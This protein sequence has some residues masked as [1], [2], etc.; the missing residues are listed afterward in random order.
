MLLGTAKAR[1]ERKRRHHQ[2]V[3][4][5]VFSACHSVLDKAGSV[6]VEDLRHSIRG[7][8]RGRNTNR[9]LSGWV[10]GLIQ[11]GVEA[12][13]RR[14]GTS[15]DEINAAY[16]SQ[17]LPCCRAF[18]RRSGDARHCPRG[19]GMFEADY[20]AANNTLQRKSD[21][22]IGRYLPYR[23][24]RQVLEE[25]SRTP[26]P[27]TLLDQRSMRGAELMPETAQA[28]LQLLQVGQRRFRRQRRKNY[29][30]AYFR[31]RKMKQV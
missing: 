29:R 30:T 1:V 26:E 8:D 22:A 23:K 20:V 21:T 19:R 6:V 9:R 13:S 25:R 27:A 5:L 11:E 15:V 24:V 14:R 7:Y 2:A 18:G 12:T 28:R 3:R 4:T 31:G 10:R 16:T 17:V